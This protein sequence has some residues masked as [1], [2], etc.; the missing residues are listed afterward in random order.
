MT[1]VLVVEDELQIAAFLDKGLRTAGFEPLI[2]REGQAALEAVRAGNFD[3]VILDLGLP[4]LDGLTVLRSLR[5][6]DSTTPV[7]ILTARDGARETVEGLDAGADDYI[8]K[9]FRL[10]VLLARVRARLRADATVDSYVIKVGN[11]TLDLRTRLAYLDDDLVELTPR[12]FAVAEN[13]FR[14]PDEVLSREQI[15]NAV[16][17]YFHDPGSNLI[18][19]YVG[20]LRKKLG[21]ELIETVRGQG[22]R[23]RA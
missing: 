5:E 20:S 9:P 7:I 17:G 22:Y 15:L 14:H 1:R 21:D 12:E 11:A 19:V 2:A 10:E 8:T 4:D 16:W 18:D 13:F 23:L 3:L 6:T